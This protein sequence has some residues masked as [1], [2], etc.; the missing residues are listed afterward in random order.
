M[1]PTMLRNLRVKNLSKK[2]VEE[3]ARQCSLIFC[4]YVFLDGWLFHIF[5]LSIDSLILYFLL[6]VLLLEVFEGSITFIPHPVLN[7]DWAK[8]LNPKSTSRLVSTK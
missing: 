3:A 1:I 8:C 2:L 7:F 6:H 4:W 5:L